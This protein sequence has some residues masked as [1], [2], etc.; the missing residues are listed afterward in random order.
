MQVAIAG[1]GR[2]GI[3]MARRLLRGGHEVVAWNRSSG[4]VE[5]I[6]AE[7]ARPAFTLEEMV[8]MLSPPRAVW[9][10]LPAGEVV[11][12]TIEQLAKLLSPGDCILD[13]GNS[14]YRDDVRRRDRLI[15]LDI[16]YLD[17]GVSGGVW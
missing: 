13:G 12:D 2:M 9:L 3:N 17:V 10:M 16:H 6:A 15:S 4:K 5:E 11:D 7:G 8:G 14:F 1:L